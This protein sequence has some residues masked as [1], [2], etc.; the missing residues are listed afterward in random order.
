MPDFIAIPSISILCY[1][2]AQGYKTFVPS[3]S[4]KHIP[5]IC[6]AAGCLIAVVSYLLIPGYIPAENMITASAI[7]VVSGGAAV[8]VNQ[9]IKQ[10]KRAKFY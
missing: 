2:I 3:Y 8:G 10:Y 4:Y 1:M 6:M 9:A 7:G 5:A